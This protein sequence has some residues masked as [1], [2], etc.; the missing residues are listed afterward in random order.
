MTSISTVRGEKEMTTAKDLRACA[1][2]CLSSVEYQNYG[3]QRAILRAL[4]TI[5]QYLAE[6]ELARSTLSDKR[7]G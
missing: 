5:C 1:D 6:Q 3:G 4:A 2:A 7:E